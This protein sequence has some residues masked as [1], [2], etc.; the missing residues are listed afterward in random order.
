MLTDV[1]APTFLA[2]SP[3]AIVLADTLSTTLLALAP[4]A[5]VR[6]PRR[7]LLHCTSPIRRLVLSLLLFPAPRL[8]PSRR[9]PLA[10]R[11]I[12]ICCALAETAI[13]WRPTLARVLVR[14]RRERE[15]RSS[16]Y[17]LARRID[18]LLRTVRGAA[19]SAPHT[20]HAL[21]VCR[22]SRVGHPRITQRLSLEATNVHGDASAIARSYVTSCGRVRRTCRA[23]EELP[24][25]TDA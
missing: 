13:H 21:V 19:V 1:L 22:Y 24:Q 20:E 9:A 11:G 12:E 17:T 8:G 6:A 25:I 18:A 23:D 5:V 3:H 2:P 15:Q 7:P 16:I 4:S 10:A 14:Q